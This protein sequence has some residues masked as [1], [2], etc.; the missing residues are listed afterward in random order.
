MALG[1]NTREI[2]TMVVAQ[3][4]SLVMVGL[5]LGLVGTFALT[6]WLG[7]LVSGLRPNDPVTFV[8]T[9]LLLTTVGFIASYVPARRATKLNPSTVLRN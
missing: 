6:R 1:A 7:S 3:A 9:T 2:L 8:I 4:M 5:I